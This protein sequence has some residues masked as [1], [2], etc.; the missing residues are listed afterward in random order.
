MG[1]PSHMRS[2]VDRNVVM[3]LITVYVRCNVIIYNVNL[4]NYVIYN[5]ITCNL[6]NQ[7]ILICYVCFQF[8]SLTPVSP[9]VSILTT[10]L[11]ILPTHCVCTFRTVPAI[12]V[13]PI[14]RTVLT[15][16][17]DS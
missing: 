2:D 11:N 12:T 15:A 10:C 5:V 13:F 1:P 8:C 16:S 14:D 3:R 9:V 4:Y 17:W 6:Y 7:F